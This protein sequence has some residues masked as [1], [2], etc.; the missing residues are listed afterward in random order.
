MHEETGGNLSE[1]ARDVLIRGRARHS[2]AVP[3]E[4]GNNVPMAA[5]LAQ[6]MQVAF[7]VLGVPMTGC[8]RGFRNYEFLR[9]VGR[10]FTCV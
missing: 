5:S 3:A 9:S 7:S 10:H 4:P 2:G 6:D 8:G 1:A